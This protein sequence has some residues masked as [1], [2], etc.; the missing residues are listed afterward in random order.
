MGSLRLSSSTEAENESFLTLRMKNWPDELCLLVSELVVSIKLSF[1]FCD[2]LTRSYQAARL[3]N[4]T[5]AFT[6]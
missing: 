6:I 3:V 1:S 4:L 5:Y 2:R